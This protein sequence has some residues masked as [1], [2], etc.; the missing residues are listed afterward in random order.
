[1]ETCPGEANGVLVGVRSPPLRGD[2]PSMDRLAGKTPG[3]T[4]RA[5]FLEGRTPCVREYGPDAY[6]GMAS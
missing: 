1:M 5:V 4:R 6:E 2:K 3:M